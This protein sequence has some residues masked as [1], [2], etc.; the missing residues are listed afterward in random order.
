MDCTRGA[1]AVTPPPV[2]HTGKPTSIRRERLERLIATHIVTKP[3][4]LPSNG[5]WIILIVPKLTVTLG[6]ES[7]P[8]G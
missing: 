1:G 7:T 5:V 2:E 8:I 4:R 3:E 6:S